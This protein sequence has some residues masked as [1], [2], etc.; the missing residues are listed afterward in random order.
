LKRIFVS[1]P[2]TTCDIYDICGGRCLYANITRRWNKEAYAVVCAT[3][4]NLA[5]AVTQEIPRIKALIENGKISME[6]FQYV[7]Y[8]GCEIIP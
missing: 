5:E 7:K 8:N 2:C 4:R 1:E 3:V 6:D